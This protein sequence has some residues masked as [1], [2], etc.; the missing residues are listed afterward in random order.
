MVNRQLHEHFISLLETHLGII[1]K[2]ARAYTR[3]F[4]DRE[5]LVSEIA[6]QMWKAFPAFK[7]KSKVSTWI[8]R[9]ALNTALNFDRRNRKRKDFLKY[10]IEIS[11]DVSP[12]GTGGNPQIELL[13]E[14]IAELDEFSKAIILL[15][16][17]GHKHDEIAE[18][19]GISTTNVGTRISRIKEALKNKVMLKQAHH[20]DQ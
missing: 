17:D 9:I 20:G 11:S 14:C 3:T 12:E 18:I 6:Y 5:D 1:L 16:L 15:Y 13:Y 8:Y 2:I 10:A 4:Q 19:T 7:G